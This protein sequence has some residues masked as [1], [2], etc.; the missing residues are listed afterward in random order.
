ML[1]FP[2][3][4]FRGRRGRARLA[5]AA[6]LTLVS[7]MYDH[8]APTLTL[9]FDR[10]V[11]IGG[12]SGSAITVEDAQENYFRYNGDGGAELLGPATVRITLIPFDDASGTGV[13]LDASALSGIVAADD[14][15]AW[16]GVS[17]LALPFP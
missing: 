4:R 17:G 14:E 7:A 13:R 10:A 6:L 15:G 9:V 1:L 5:P 11:D 8:T 3:P 16:A 2:I 12:F